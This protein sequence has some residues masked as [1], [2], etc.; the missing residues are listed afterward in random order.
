MIGAATTAISP[1]PSLACRD[2]FPRDLGLAQPDGVSLTSGNGSW[3]AMR[4][5]ENACGKRGLALSE[6][7]VAVAVAEGAIGLA[8]QCSAPSEPET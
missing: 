8:R 4:A 7:A 1:S 5:T 3:T 6:S 2:R